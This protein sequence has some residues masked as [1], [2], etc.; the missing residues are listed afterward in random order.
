[1]MMIVFIFVFYFFFMVIVWLFVFLGQIFDELNNEN[2][3]DESFDD[4][5][6]DFVFV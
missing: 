2:N 3:C 5:V 4:D 6:G 1:M